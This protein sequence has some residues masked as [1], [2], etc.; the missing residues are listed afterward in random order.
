VRIDRAREG[1]TGSGGGI[2]SLDLVIGVEVRWLAERLAWKG[3]EVRRGVGMM[4]VWGT[5]VF[6]R[7]LITRREI[8]L[9]TRFHCV[10]GE[11]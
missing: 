6:E 9:E 2:A 1:R 7:K 8:F 10:A 4:G 3:G 11:R 5:V